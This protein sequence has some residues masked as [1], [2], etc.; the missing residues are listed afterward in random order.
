MKK[1]L[2]DKQGI[3][4]SYNNL[5]ILEK[6]KEDYPEALKMQF[7]ALAI[8]ESIGDKENISI[9]NCNLGLLQVLTKKFKDAERCYDKALA[10]ALEIGSKSLVT[11]SYRNLAT[12]YN[13]MSVLKG[14]TSKES[15]AYQLKA[16]EFYKQYTADMEAINKKMED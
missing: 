7:A 14:V 15:N 4:N 1:E 8:Y 3:A 6:K 5:A 12:L 10:L 13:E 2:G 16:L 9:S 11:I